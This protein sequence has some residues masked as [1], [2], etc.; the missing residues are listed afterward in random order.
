MVV[1]MASECK[2]PLLWLRRDSMPTV[3]DHDEHMLLKNS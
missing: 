2:N 1:D 3:M